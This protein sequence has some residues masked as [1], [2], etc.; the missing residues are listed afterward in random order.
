MIKGFSQGI[1]RGSA[2]EMVGTRRLGSPLKGKTR[3]TGATK[4]C[5]PCWRLY[6]AS[7]TA[8]DRLSILNR[9][10]EGI[11]S[12]QRSETRPGRQKGQKSLVAPSLRV[13]GA[14]GGAEKIEGGLGG[15]CAGRKN[16]GRVP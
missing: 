1:C 7:T 12:H 5:V 14:G 16:L 11:H 13:S 15:T 2:G 3:A 10:G 4:S 6:S 8:S 9:S